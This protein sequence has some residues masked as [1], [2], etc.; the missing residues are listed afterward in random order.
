MKLNEN[1]VMF[2][3]HALRV[4]ADKFDEDAKV[5]RESERVSAAFDGYARR[6]RKLAD[7]LEDA[8]SVKVLS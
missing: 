2:L 5:V 6:S 3:V 4:A 8:H 1:D 7:R